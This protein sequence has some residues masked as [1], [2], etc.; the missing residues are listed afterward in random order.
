MNI[1]I[2][3]YNSAVSAAYEVGTFRVV[4]CENLR[5]KLLIY[6]PAK[7]AELLRSSHYLYSAECAEIH[8]P[9]IEYEF[10]RLLRI[11]KKS[12]FD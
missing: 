12:H 7:F 10:L 2:Q 3:G 4:F 9:D 5:E 6:F 1:G 11:V 8:H